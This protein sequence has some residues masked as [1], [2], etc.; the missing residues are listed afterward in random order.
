[1]SARYLEIAS[2]A[3]FHRMPNLLFYSFYEF[4]WGGPDDCANRKFSHKISDHTGCGDA[5]SNPLF[6]FDVKVLMEFVLVMPNE[7]I[8]IL[9]PLLFLKNVTPIHNWNKC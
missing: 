8:V 9:W 2:I 3:I 4:F 5:F 6:R 7:L 1:M